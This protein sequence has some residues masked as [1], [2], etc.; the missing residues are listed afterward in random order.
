MSNVS[1]NWDSALASYSMSQTLDLFICN[2]GDMQKPPF[3]LASSNLYCCV[4]EKFVKQWECLA[5][6]LEVHKCFSGVS[7]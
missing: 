2:A 7:T 4:Q 3:S 5:C 6:S 1:R